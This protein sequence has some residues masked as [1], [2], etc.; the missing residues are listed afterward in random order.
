MVHEAAVFM[1]LLVPDTAQTLVSYIIIT[2]RNTLL[3]EVQYADTD[4]TDLLTGE[5]IRSGE[6][7]TISAW[8]LKMI[9]V[10]E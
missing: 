1:E 9:E 4:G 6:R 8:D 3:Q 2:G 5:N 7:F 10:L